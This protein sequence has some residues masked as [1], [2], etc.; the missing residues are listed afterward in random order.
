MRVD[1]GHFPS[2]TG[3]CEKM[4]YPVGWAAGIFQSSGCCGYQK[5]KGLS[6]KNCKVRQAEVEL[7]QRPG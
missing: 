4:L 1:R 3:E 5:P 2:T 7:R 6:S